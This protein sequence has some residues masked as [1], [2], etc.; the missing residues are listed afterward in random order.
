MAAIGTFRQVALA[1]AIVDVVPIIKYDARDESL[2]RRL[3][4]VAAVINAD[5]C[6]MIC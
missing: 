3:R 6:T 2:C 5:A 4:L 1:D